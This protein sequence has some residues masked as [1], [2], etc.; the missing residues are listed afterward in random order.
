MRESMERSKRERERE[1]ERQKKQDS[2]SFFFDISK[3]KLCHVANSVSKLL[4][5]TL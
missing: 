4:F 2:F 1:R 5:K 3:Q